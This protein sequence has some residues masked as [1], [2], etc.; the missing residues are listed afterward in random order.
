[1]RA[2]VALLAACPTAAALSWSPVLGVSLVVLAI[3]AG[4]DAQS[5]RPA[6]LATLGGAA[7]AS[8]A[9][10]A[11]YDPAHRL[12]APVPVP[13]VDRRLLRIGL[14]ALVAVPVLA[15]V[16]ELSP[17]PEGVWAPTLAL[18][19]TGLALATWLPGERRTLVAAAV[20][21]AW[22]SATRLLGDSAGALDVWA[23]HPRLQA[24][25]AGA[26]VV[27]GWHR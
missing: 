20:P 23:T 8:A 26:A 16:R 19:L 24:T 18:V 1:M 15:V 21:T 27:A 6:A 10:A 7:V 3:A 2:R 4:V 14:V 13:A 5:D 17:A 22:A 25:A 12:L 11:L 9:I